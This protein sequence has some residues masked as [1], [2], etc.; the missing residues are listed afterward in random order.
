MRCSTRFALPAYTRRT[1]VY[2][3]RVMEGV[4]SSPRSPCRA[5]T[6]PPAPPTTTATT[7]GGPQMHHRFKAPC[8]ARTRGR[9]ALRLALAILGSC[10]LLLGLIAPAADAK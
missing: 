6:C 8:P 10:V 1:H 3:Y 7:H 5:R 9:P 2:F 4:T